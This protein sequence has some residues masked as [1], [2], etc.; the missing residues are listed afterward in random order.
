VKGYRR[1]SVVRRVALILTLLLAAG[2]VPPMAAARQED[3]PGTAAPDVTPEGQPSGPAERADV[4]ADWWSAVQEQIRRSEYRVSWQAQTY[5]TGLAA[6]YQAPNRAQNLRAYFTP[7]GPIVIPR[8]WAEET[9]VPPWRWEMRLA[10]W[11]RSG[12]L[13]TVPEAALDAQD[14]RV[15]YRRGDPSAGPGLIEAYRNDEQGL[16]QTFTVPARPGTAEAAGPLQLALDLGGDL[17]PEIVDERA[18][19]AFRTADGRDALRYGGLR[20]EDA[21][22]ELLAAGLALE[23]AT[24]SIRIEDAAATYPIQA[25]ARITGLPTDEDWWLTFGQ[26]GAEF[27]SSVATAGDVDGDGYSEVIIGAPMYDDGLAEAGAVFVYY[28]SPGGLYEF[29]DWF[30][31]GGQTGAHFGDSAAT[32]GDVNGDGYADVI[33]GAPGYTDGQ[34][35]EGGA[36]VW[37]GSADGLEDDWSKHAQGNRAGAAFGLS[38]ATAG[39]VNGDGYSDVIV[40]APLHHLG[41]GPSEE[42]VVWVWHGSPDGLQD[43]SWRAE[44]EQLEASLGQSVATAGD[45]NAD[46]YADVIVGATRYTAGH[47]SE[48]AAFVWLGSASGLN[49]GVYGN[50]SNAHRHLQINQATARFGWSVSTAGDVNGDGY[51]DV[52]VGA[53]YYTNGDG[54]EGGAWL[55][56]GSSGG[57][58]AT[59]ANQDEGNQAGAHLGWSVATAGD[60]NGDGRADVIVGAPDY[61]VGLDQQGRAWL[62]YGQPTAH[63]IS[64]TN[65]WRAAGAQRE[66]FFGTSVATA[67]DVDGD[68][69]SDVIVGAPGHASAAGR[70]TVYHGGPDPLAEEAGWTKASNQANAAFG[71]SVGTAGDVNGDGYADV[72]VGAPHWDGGQDNEGAAWVY[73]GGAGGLTS[74]PHWYKRSNNAGAAFGAS[75]GTAGDVNG[76]G[77]DDVI[78]G[79]PH[80]HVPQTD[81]GAAFVYDGSSSG[82]DQTAG[83]L[84]S[85][86]SDQEGAEFGASVGAAGDVNGDGYADIIVGA[87]FWLHKGEE[88]GAVWLYYGSPGG[89]HSAP[90]WYQVGDQEEAQYGYAVGTGGDVDGDGYSDVIVGSPY[91]EDEVPNVSEGR[92]WV[93]LGSRAGLRH[94]LHWHAEANNFVARMGHA[95]GTAGDVDGDGYSD[96][97]VGAPGYGDDGLSGEGKVWV[98]HGSRSG[99]EPSSSWSRE[100]GQ[101]GAHYGWSV[102]TAGDVN[103]DGYADIIIGVELLTDGE[104]YEGGASVYHGSYSGLQGSRAWHGEGDQASAHYGTSVGT[105]GDVN[106]D[107]YADV[108]VGAPQYNAPDPDEGQ[109]FLYYGNGGLGLSLNPRQVRATSTTTPIARL[110]WSDWTDAFCI[111]LRTQRPFGLGRAKIE[112]EVKPLGVPFDGA[113]TLR[114]TSWWAEPIGSSR[115]L[116][117]TDLQAGTRYHW[118]ARWR[119][120]PTTSPWLPASRWVTMPWNGRNEQDLRTAGWR[121]LLPLVLREY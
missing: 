76:D 21:S 45:V 30:K 73:L 17:V 119:Y 121:I 99:L 101:N 36:W 80:W 42:G 115:Y 105:A 113:N 55:Y 40:G 44:G 114:Q 100:G 79:A 97:I 81:E 90:D 15:T 69:Y 66:A 107:G 77:Y 87:P 102:G 41:M 29:S 28:G 110:G 118:R 96:V 106:G 23:G 108:V 117:A 19:I 33:V 56:L 4:G 18:E 46:G 91:W 48:G 26:E 5:L 13:D 2:S 3:P 8:T 104:N 54:R 89:P 49:G 98:F 27:G 86:A 74:A 32:A 53:P 71:T 50:P 93:Y 20:V 38:V 68:G 16:L 75:V 84:W 72:I 7:Q 59:A 112:I 11:G 58:S 95:V 78:V 10:A 92:A 120:R 1:L 6:A 37:H 109:A 47:D 94:D 52:I 64:T 43:W 111:R 116:C 57:L 85:K 24:L 9:S 82:L 22:G 25:E 65:D 83:P 63:G 39:D 14:N 31:T 60:V 35:G 70:C 62:W 51:A 88:R 67:G 12:R 61:T 34:E 103:G